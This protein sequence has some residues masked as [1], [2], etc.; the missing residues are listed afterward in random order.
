MQPFRK[1]VSYGFIAAVGQVAAI[2]QQRQISRRLSRGRGGPNIKHAQNERCSA[3]VLCAA[4]P[5]RSPWSE[6]T[7]LFF[8]C[9]WCQHFCRGI[10][11]P[12]A[13]LSGVPLVALIVL[14]RPL[15][16]SS[17][18]PLALCSATLWS[19][20]SCTTAHGVCCMPVSIIQVAPLGCA[21]PWEWNWDDSR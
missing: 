13:V 15:C 18:H 3:G 16:C 17:R 20:C 6:A 9:F 4:H 21:V 14:R 19:A 8:F 7:A 11:I 2:A 12:G 5:C 10:N 1:W